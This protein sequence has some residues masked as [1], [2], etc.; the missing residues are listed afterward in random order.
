MFAAILL[1]IDIKILNN[2]LINRNLLEQMDSLYSEI[3][4]REEWEYVAIGELADRIAMEP[5]GSNIKVSTF[6]VNLM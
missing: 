5:F 3:S 1:L 2:N 4:K 6:Q